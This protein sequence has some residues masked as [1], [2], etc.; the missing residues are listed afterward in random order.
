MPRALR[1]IPPGEPVEVMT[2]T[3]ESRRMLPM[4]PEFRR[5]SAGTLARAAEKYDVQVHA[6]VMLASHYHMILTPKDGGELA[7]F[8]GFVNGNLA[9]QALRHHKRSGKLWG[10]RYHAVLISS[11]PEAQEARLRYLL[12]NA[13]KED[14]VERVGDWQGLHCAQALIDDEP[15][16]GAWQDQTGLYKAGQRWEA[17]KSRGKS[18][19]PV[20]PRDFEKEYKLELA[21][22]PCWAEL[23]VKGRRQKVREMVVEVEASAAARRAESGKTVLGMLAVQRQNP[24]SRPAK[25]KRSPKPLVHAATRKVREVYRGAYRAFVA[26]FRAASELLLGGDRQA[27]FPCWSFPPASAFVREGEAILPVG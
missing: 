14:L 5:R 20:D 18:T 9:R 8:M 13:V 26:A 3:L 21:P 15:I 22:L 17:F 16:V 23:S 19:E 2:R 1:W 12:S 27:I 10:G 7:R 11:E 4:T 25:T 6:V 24:D